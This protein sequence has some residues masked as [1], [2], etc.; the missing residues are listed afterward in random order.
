M[1]QNNM[2]PRNNVAFGEITMKLEAHREKD[3]LFQALQMESAFPQDASIRM[4]EYRNDGD[5]YKNITINAQPQ[6]ERKIS[7]ALSILGISHTLDGVSRPGLDAFSSLM[8][9]AVRKLKGE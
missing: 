1:I 9:E 2:L 6:E 8:R 7:N 5:T 3:K 4:S